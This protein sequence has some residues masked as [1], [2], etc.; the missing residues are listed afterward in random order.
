[1]QT[2]INYKQYIIM[3]KILMALALLAIIAGCS[4][5]SDGTGG[6]NDNPGQDTKTPYFTLE[7]P[8]SIF[9]IP[10]VIS[11]KSYSTN[12]DT[13]YV[14]SSETWCKIKHAYHAFEIS[15]DKYGRDEQGNLQPPRMAK[16]SIT[17]GNIYK[18]T[19][20]VIEESDVAAISAELHG[21]A[22]RISPAGETITQSILSN[23]FRWKATTDA[24]WLTLKYIDNATLQITSSPRPDNVT[25][26]RRAE[27]KLESVI[28]YRI[29]GSFIVEEAD[30][31]AHPGD[32]EYGE[33]SDWD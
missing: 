20:T 27:V 32:Y 25:T 14:T 11:R 26:R 2:N 33:H 28:N 29:T 23:C 17:A 16:V 7:I 5:E 4:K 21:E 12:L 31:E 9:L 24:N 3:K 8:D 10:D 18:K 19:I 6:G 22:L 13:V 1:M 30:P 15:V